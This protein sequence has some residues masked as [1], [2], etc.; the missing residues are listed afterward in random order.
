MKA[1]FTWFPTAC[2]ARLSAKKDHVILDFRPVLNTILGKARE[3]SA[4]QVP[5]FVKHVVNP[6]IANASIPAPGPRADS[7][8]FVCIPVARPNCTAFFSRRDSFINSSCQA[9]KSLATAL[10]SE[11]CATKLNN[12]D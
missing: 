9:D 4:R 8:I 5:S 2:S 6:L 10:Q 3:A 7:L 1:W 11:Q 12:V